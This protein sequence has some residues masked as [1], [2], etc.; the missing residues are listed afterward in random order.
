MEIFTYLSHVMRRTNI[1]IIFLS[2][3]FAVLSCDD[4]NEQ[5]G[6]KFLD[7]TAENVGIQVGEPHVTVFKAEGDWKAEIVEPA[8]ASEWLEISPVSG[9]AGEDNRI[10]LTAIQPNL[11]EKTRGA[12]VKVSLLDNS[13][14]GDR[15]TVRQDRTSVFIETIKTNPSGSMELK[16]GETRII[17]TTYTPEYANTEL[18]MTWQKHGGEDL[19]EITPSKNGHSASVKGLKAGGPAR[20]AVWAVSDPKSDASPMAEIQI[21]VTNN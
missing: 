16:V 20:L 13:M 8:D 2:C 6:I 17:T 7:G 15:F 18:H 3:L 5:K 12:H 21:T 4:S 11:S 10:E 14:P 1:F 9:P 19:Y